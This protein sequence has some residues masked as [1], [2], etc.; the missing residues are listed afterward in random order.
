MAPLRASE[1]RGAAA[2]H[3]RASPHCSWL[4]LKTRF[5]VFLVFLSAGDARRRPP[6]RRVALLRGSRPFLEDRWR[7]GNVRNKI[8]AKPRSREQRER[9]AT[10]GGTGGSG[11][12]DARRS[13]DDLR[14]KASEVR[15]AG[16]RGTGAR[17]SRRRTDAAAPGGGRRAQRHG[18]DGERG[19]DDARGRRPGARL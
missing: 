4:C 13:D 9:G 17:A 16:P 19:R 2:R 10:D 5:R 15:A 12:R 1:K 7:P 14:T 8:G 18:E 6:G 11:T 3:V